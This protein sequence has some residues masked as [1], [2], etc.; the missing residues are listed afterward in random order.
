MVDENKK[1][2][3]E[4]W[5]AAYG[6]HLEQVGRGEAK[7]PG[8]NHNVQALPADARSIQELQNH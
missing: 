2:V 5:L 8:E 4:T 1:T 7:Q 6:T 3:F